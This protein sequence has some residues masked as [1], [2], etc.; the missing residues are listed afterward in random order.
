MTLGE[1]RKTIFNGLKELGVEL[2]GKQLS[3]LSKKIKEYSRFHNETLLKEI[4]K[5]MEAKTKAKTFTAKPKKEP[6]PKGMFDMPD[7]N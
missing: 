4:Q 5:F 3:F 7:F 1:F 2:E 6:K